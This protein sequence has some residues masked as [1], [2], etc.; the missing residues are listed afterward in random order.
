M[1]GSATALQEIVHYAEE[2]S[3]Q[4]LISFKSHFKSPPLDF[5]SMAGS[6]FAVAG[7]AVSD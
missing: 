3:N 5:S 6:P 2:N 4:F 7:V 1:S